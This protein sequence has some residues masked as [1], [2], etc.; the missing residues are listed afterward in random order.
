MVTYLCEEF[1]NNNQGVCALNTLLGL[2]LLVVKDVVGNIPK[3]ALDLVLRASPCGSKN[4]ACDTL[5]VLCT[6]LICPVIAALL[7]HLGHFLDLH[8]RLDGSLHGTPGLLDGVALVLQP[9]EETGN[10]AND[11]L[12]ALR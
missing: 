6:L 3:H 7:L 11:R 4:L 5:L 1:T 10:T 12:L 8:L 2:D 9:G